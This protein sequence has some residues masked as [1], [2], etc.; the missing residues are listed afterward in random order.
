MQNTL[1]KN[2]IE[3]FKLLQLLQYFQISPNILQEIWCNFNEK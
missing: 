1:D 3:M 2:I